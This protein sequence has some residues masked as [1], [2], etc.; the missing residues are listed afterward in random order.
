MLCTAYFPFPSTVIGLLSILSASQMYELLVPSYDDGIGH[1]SSPRC[2]ARTN[3]YQKEGAL[4]TALGDK[5]PTRSA[6]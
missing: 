6:W 5:P 4:L 1:A 2:T 3:S